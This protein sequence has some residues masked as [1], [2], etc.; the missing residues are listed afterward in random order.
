[1]R[2]LV[3][4]TMGVSFVCTAS[5]A[6]AQWSHYT[7][8][9][10]GIQ[11]D[12]FWG[13]ISVTTNDTL[14]VTAD[15]PAGMP[16]AGEAHYST[17]AYPIGPAPW[18]KT[19]YNDP[20]YPADFAQM[21]KVRKNWGTDQFAE[22][23]MG[24]YSD[25]CAGTS[26]YFAAWFDQP[27]GYQGT[28]YFDVP[29]TAGLHEFEIGQKPDQTIDFLLDG[30]VQYTLTGLAMDFQDTSLRNESPITSS[31]EFASYSA[32]SG[33]DSV[34]AQSYQIESLG[35]LAGRGSSANAASA[36]GFVA[37]GSAIS[38]DF[39]GTPW[40]AHAFRWYRGENIDLGVLGPDVPPGTFPK[41][42]SI[43]LG[44]NSLGQVV[45]KSAQPGQPYKGF[46]WLPEPAYGFPAGMN[47]LPEL[48]G[49][50]TIANKINDAGQIVGESRPEGSLSSR[51]VLWTYD[52]TQWVIEDLGTLGGPYG[53]AQSINSKGQVVGQANATDGSLRS[54]LWLPA[55]DYGMTAGMH[56][57]HASYGSGNAFDVNNQG[58]V[59][60]AIGLGAA[61]IWLPAPAYGLPAGL[62]LFDLSQIPSAAGAWPNA[63]NEHGVVVGQFAQTVY[64]GQHAT[65][66][67]HYSGF[68]WEAGVI[69]L[70]D[71]FLPPGWDPTNAL[72]ITDGGKIVGVGA[73][74]ELPGYGLGYRMTPV[75][76]GDLNC[77]GFING[78]D[79]D[80]FVLALTDEAAY[81]EH[82]PDCNRSNADVNGDG[83]VN[84][85]DIDPFVELL[86][87]N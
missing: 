53:R 66:A 77:D 2:K 21:I 33:Y 54:F 4:L 56:D 58:Q 23:Y 27:T 79:I 50:S 81:D 78:Y 17:S 25:S 37:G 12:N 55:P 87:G 26:G 49:G 71:E 48:P 60:G 47:E 24:A 15:Q 10:M 46:L 67:T 22:V 84:G 80:P 7:V 13:D 28:I 38:G 62:N 41:P 36:A 45:G 85:Y 31:A 68:R 5:T 65:R 30:Q 82:W 72:D 20:G 64:D 6:Q 35:D 61:Y 83:D 29:R 32:G 40:F 52:G 75:T 18:V 86:V 69:H 70:L 57:L 74:P 8:E 14:L 44:V 43:G 39:S 59:V 42:E 16:F 34:P 73:S 19:T 63:I 1:M 11:W 51:P 3:L 9:W 76:P